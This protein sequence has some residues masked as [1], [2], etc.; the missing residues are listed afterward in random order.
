MTGDQLTGSKDNPTFMTVIFDS[1]FVQNRPAGK[2][3]LLRLIEG[4]WPS[5]MKNVVY[6]VTFWKS[7]L[8]NKIIFLLFNLYKSSVNYGRGL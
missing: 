2:G 8:K 6:D 1:K 4:L 5:F 3:F 7:K